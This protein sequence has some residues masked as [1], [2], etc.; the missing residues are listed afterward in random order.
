MSAKRHFVVPDRFSTFT[1]IDL[2]RDGDAV[3]GSEQ[4]SSSSYGGSIPGCDVGSCQDGRVAEFYQRS[5][6]MTPPRMAQC[7]PETRCYGGSIPGFSQ[8]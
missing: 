8:P 3:C 1:A 7:S 4:P 5:P 6:G 2:P